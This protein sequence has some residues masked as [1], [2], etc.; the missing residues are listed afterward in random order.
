M[1]T[2]ETTKPK[3]TEPETTK[4]AIKQPEKE[5][6]EKTASLN[7]KTTVKEELP[8]SPREVAA[9]VAADG[10]ERTKA[11]VKVP[12]PKTDPEITK[13]KRKIADLEADNIKLKAQLSYMVQGRRVSTVIDAGTP[14]SCI[15]GAED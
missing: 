6:Q 1:T 12:K 9:Q 2:I 10:A 8:S 4:P 5:A 13:L 15:D 3:T 11:E 7:P 14:V